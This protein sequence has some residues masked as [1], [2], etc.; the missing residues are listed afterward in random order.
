MSLTQLLA[1]LLLLGSLPCL[2]GG[3]QVAWQDP[4]AQEESV[5][6]LE[7]FVLEWTAEAEP[8]P[9]RGRGDLEV[10]RSRVLGLARMRQRLE[11]DE[12]QL[13]VEYDYFLED[14]RLYAVER[15]GER[16][17]RLVFREMAAGR[18]RTLRAEW[19]RDGVSL[20]TAEWDRGGRRARTASLEEGGVLPQYLLELARSGRALSGY[21]RVFDPL[22]G[23]LEAQE[24]STSYESG[25]EEQLQRVVRL[26]RS[27]G[28]LAGEYRFTGE[29]LTA[30]RLQNGRI[31]AH[32]VSEEVYEE[33]RALF[34]AGPTAGSEP[35]SGDPGE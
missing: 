21:F 24:L 12:L 33:A 35:A 11:G 15:L 26:V 4:P 10:R 23:G 14:L 30:F 32:A 34:H 1:R 9:A 28:T 31:A 2:G 29:A 8:P 19:S 25:A 27:D 5:Q 18:G 7:H 20:E 13:E 17:S 16:A 22:S 6:R 3:A